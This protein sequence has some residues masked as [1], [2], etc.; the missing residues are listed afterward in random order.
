MSRVPGEGLHRLEEALG[1]RFRD[2]SLLRRAVVHRS[3]SAEQ[4]DEPSYERLEFLGDAVLQLV[5]TDFV[6]TEYPDLEEGHMAKVRSASVSGT[7]L[8]LLAAQLDLGPHLLLGKGEEGSGGRS[9]SSILADVVESVLAAVY[10]DG[11]LQAA[12]EVI[13]GLWEQRIRVWARQP[14]RRD[15]KTRLQELLA[16][17]GQQP[18]YR[19]VGEGPD[20]AMTFTSTVEVEGRVVGYGA[21]S[22]KKEAEQR[23]AGQALERLE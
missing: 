10:L 6:F 21:G 23:A 17:R 11:G 3:Y 13:L 9:K 7:E 15:Y 22:S 1:Y 8:A 18:E 19:T 14:G 16:R 4:P 5:V 20:H 2:P 12:R